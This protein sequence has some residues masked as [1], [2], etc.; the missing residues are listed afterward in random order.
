MA[1]QALTS[2]AVIGD[3]YR[4]LEENSGAT[5]VG[6]TSMLFQS[7]QPIEEYAWLGMSPKMREWVG[8]R[9]A[10][11][12]KE[13]TIRIPNKW[14]EAT[15]EV[16][17]DDLRRDKSGQLRI[18]IAE[19]ARRTQTHW[20]QLLNTLILNGQ[21]ALAYDGQA[22]FSTTHAEDDSGT[23]SNHI[24]VNVA[25]P[26][27]PSASEMETAI[28]RAVT[29]IMAI[30]DNTGEP[31]N[32]DASSFLVMVPTS[33][34]ASAAAALRNPVIVDTNGSRTNTLTN[35]GGFS[36]ELAINPRLTA[37]DEFYVFRSDSMVRAFIR[38]EEQAVRMDAVAEGSE[39]EFKNRRH[40]YG[41]TAIR[42]VG[43]GMWQ[44]AVL[45][46]LT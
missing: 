19:L 11:G 45:V 29:Q 36:F 8:G 31:M 41:V 28:L 30:K 24:Q 33:M 35:L 37:T 34:M 1:L 22:F 25:D 15:L 20:A 10:K 43:Y 27:A 6:P 7:N 23:Q 17:L 14:F 40:L 9:L 21:S 38:Q 13:T 44:E 42:N 32:E 12:L 26:N 18:R 16:Y 2:R 46:E 5:W 39:E 3:F 4:R